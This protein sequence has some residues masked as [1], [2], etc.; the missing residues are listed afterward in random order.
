MRGECEWQASAGA[1][2]G[3][4]LDKVNKALGASAPDPQPLAPEAEL[5]PAASGSESSGGARFF[6]ELAQLIAWRSQGM[7]SEHEF[8]QAKARLMGN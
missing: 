5:P 7:L 4:F 1:P 2:L 6:S 8:A 3:P